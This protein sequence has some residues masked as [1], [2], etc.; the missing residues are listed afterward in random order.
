MLQP[1]LWI[2]WISFSLSIGIYGL[3]VLFPN[4]PMPD[5]IRRFYKYGKAADLHRKSLLSMLDLPKR[6][7][8]T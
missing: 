8:A 2:Q 6:C 1:L 4:V 7:A 5:E 3:L